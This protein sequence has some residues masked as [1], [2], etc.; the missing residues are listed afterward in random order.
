MRHPQPLRCG[1]DIE[2]AGLAQRDAHVALA[3]TFR[4]DLPP[5]A[6][7]ELFP[8]DGERDEDHIAKRSLRAGNRCSRQRMRAGRSTAVAPESESAA[9]AALVGLS[10][11]V[12][13]MI[14]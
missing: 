1:D 12:V 4:F 3:G 5:R 10:G 2:L 14:G 6:G 7:G 13:Q 9:S 8:G 11:R